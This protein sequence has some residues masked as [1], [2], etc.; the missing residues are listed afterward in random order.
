M[1]N[2]V[3]VLITYNSA[4]TRTSTQKD[5]WS[6]QKE[7]AD[8]S[9][10]SESENR[11]LLFRH[12]VEKVTG[13][14]LFLIYYFHIVCCAVGNL[15]LVTFVRSIHTQRKKAVWDFS[16]DE[17]FGIQSDKIRVSL[18]CVRMFSYTSRSART[19]IP[20]PSIQ[21]WE[22]WTYLNPSW[23]ESKVVSFLQLYSTHPQQ[24]STTSILSEFL[25]HERWLSKCEDSRNM[26]I[27]F[28]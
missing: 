4:W 19:Q 21:Y 17:K 26:R 22:L 12:Y 8:Y 14:V 1:F 25:V 6:I 2:V 9:I 23:Y 13:I 20:P 16:I 3:S 28:E 15:F 7:L 11:F 5:R 10:F 24:H 18:I 27:F